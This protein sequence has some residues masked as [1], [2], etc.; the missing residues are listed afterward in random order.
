MNFGDNNQCIG[1]LVGQEHKGLS[2]MFHMMNEARIFVGVG[3]TALGQA[4]YQASLNYARE[5][6]QG[7]HPDAKDAASNQ[8]A[9]IEHADIRRL[10]LAQKAA[11]E[12]AFALGLYCARLV[13]ITRSSNDQNQ[14]DEANLLLEMLTP[15]TKSWPSE[16]CL[17]S[18][19]HAL[20]VLG[21][22]GYIRD[23]PI[24]RYYRDN[25]LNPIHEGTHGIQGLDFLGRKSRMLN[26]KG[27]E[28]LVA[29][30]QTTIDIA[31]Q[32]DASK[33]MADQ[34]DNALTKFQAVSVHLITQLQTDPRAGLANATLYLD[35]GGHIVMAW[36]HLRIVL[37]TA[38]VTSN[39]DFVKGKWQSARYFYN[40]ELVRSKQ[41]SKTLLASE[42]SAYEMQDNWF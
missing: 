9:I 14:I 27:L 42:S 37:A 1:Y 6:P 34:L 8:V 15:I 29:K 23:Y 11:I 19:K 38:K 31:R 35:L 30:I 2:Y 33:E 39:D 36:M 7:R 41:W 12:P 16:F 10:L 24:E 21:G 13:D 28:L 32:T 4:G 3:A 5:R 26:G 40:R 17:E 18:N 20:Q 22:A 25:R